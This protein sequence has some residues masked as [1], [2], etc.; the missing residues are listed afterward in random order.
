MLLKSLVAYAHF[1]A[2]FGVVATLVFEWLTYSRNPS[3]Q[4][5]KRLIAVDR[6]Y[7]MFAGLVLIAGTVRLVYFEK[8]WAFYRLMPFFHLKLG[9]FLLMGLLSIYPTM[10]FLRWRTDIRAGR[11]PAVTE[12]QH[13]AISA[14]LNVQMMLIAVLLLSASLMANGVGA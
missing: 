9:V 13:R 3:A 7:G 4:D 8:G 6:W 14:C 12:A 2:A 11:A 1:V 10:R 5:A